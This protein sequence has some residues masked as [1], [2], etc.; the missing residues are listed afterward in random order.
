[1]QAVCL[2]QEVN[3]REMAVFSRKHGDFVSLLIGNMSK[4]VQPFYFGEQRGIPRAA[5]DRPADEL[6]HRRSCRTRVSV[7]LNLK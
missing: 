3:R 7:Q 4:A 2:R 6:K 5:H 1:M